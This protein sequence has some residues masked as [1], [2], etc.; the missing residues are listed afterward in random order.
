MIAKHIFP[1]FNVSTGRSLTESL[2]T[3]K[4]FDKT[5]YILK[6]MGK[7]YLLW[8]KSN[9]KAY[10]KYVCKKN[11]EAKLQKMN[12]ITVC[13]DYYVTQKLVVLHTSVFIKLLI[14]LLSI[15]CVK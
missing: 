10:F 12:L 14:F 3:D 7:F 6:F 15:L 9:F 13:L 1:N 5:N 11:L 8:L 4:R 2:F